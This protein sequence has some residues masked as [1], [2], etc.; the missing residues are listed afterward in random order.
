METVTVKWLESQ[1][2]CREGV[3]RFTRLYGE[4]APLQDVEVINDDDL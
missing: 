4:S 3:D 1:N 2:A